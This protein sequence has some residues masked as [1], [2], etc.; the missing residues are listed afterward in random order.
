MREITFALPVAFQDHLPREFKQPGVVL[1]MRLPVIDKVGASQPQSVKVAKRQIGPKSDRAAR[2]CWKLLDGKSID[3]QLVTAGSYREPTTCKQ[4]IV[5]IEP[6]VQLR[7]QC[8]SGRILEQL[9]A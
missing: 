1:E 8:L 5:V 9:I 2:R 7:G 6:S 4:C 3:F